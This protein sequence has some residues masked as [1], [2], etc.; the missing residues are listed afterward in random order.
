MQENDEPM[1]GHM[2]MHQGELVADAQG[3]DC[4]PHLA[5]EG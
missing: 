2:R 3:A 4:Q 5:R 1:V